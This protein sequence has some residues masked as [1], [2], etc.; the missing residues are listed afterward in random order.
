MVSPMVFDCHKQDKSPLWIYIFHDELFLVEQ[1]V[2]IITSDKLL[3]L[4]LHIINLFHQ[5]KKK[6]AWLLCQASF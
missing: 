5:S 4:T 6:D 3:N 2:K 1:Y